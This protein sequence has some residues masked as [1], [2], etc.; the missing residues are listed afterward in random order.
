[1][2]I[3]VAGAAGAF[4]RKH[5]QAITA[6]NEV[7][8]ASIVDTVP[9]SIQEIAKE[10]QI[11]MATLNADGSLGTVKDSSYEEFEKAL[12]KAKFPKRVFIKEP[13]FDD[14]KDIF[15]KNVEVLLHY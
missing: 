9:D 3:C 1:M 10:Q 8:V 11:E 6:I 7:E 13:I 2:K 15:G 12:A 14:M 5:L 4:G